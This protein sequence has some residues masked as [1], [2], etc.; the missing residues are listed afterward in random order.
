MLSDQQLKAL[1]LSRAQ[2][3]MDAIL[4]K[5]VAIELEGSH[6]AWD[7]TDLRTVFNAEL[8][9]WYE[10]ARFEVL[11]DAQNQP[12]GFVDEDKWAGCR[13]LPLPRERLLELLIGT[14]F[15]AETAAIA[16][17]RRGKDN[18]VEMVVT[19]DAE[20]ADAPRFLARVNAATERVISVMPME[21]EP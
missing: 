14:G 2:T 12:I 13:W 15:L 16:D 8:A 17:L 20:R 11:L 10:T 6:V 1:A 19:A 5:K 3:H 18:C 4:K 7:P 9:V 21:L